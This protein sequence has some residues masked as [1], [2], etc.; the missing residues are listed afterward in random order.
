MSL[1]KNRLQ[2]SKTVYSTAGDNTCP[3]CFKALRKCQCSQS[4]TSPAATDVI[5][6]GRETKGRKG[7]GVT[8]ITGLN[9]SA[10]DFS[11]TVKKLKTLCGSGGTVKKTHIE[12]QGDHRDLVRKNLEEL[13]YKVKLSGG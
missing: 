8:V 6:I 7:K 2:S 4:K 10:A 9:P 3:V 1:S 5:R 12:L 13:G 11:S